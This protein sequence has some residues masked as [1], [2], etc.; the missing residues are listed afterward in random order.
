[1]STLADII[2][3]L[4]KEQEIMKKSLERPGP[5]RW[6]SGECNLTKVDK[7]RRGWGGKSRYG[8]NSGQQWTQNIAVDDDAGI[9]NI[10]GYKLDIKK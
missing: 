10:A 6:V 5:R 8:S 4:E 2:E 3:E 1:M 9:V 7:K